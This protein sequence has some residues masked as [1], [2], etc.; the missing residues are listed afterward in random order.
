MNGCYGNPPP[1][2]LSGFWRLGKL[3][4]FKHCCHSC[5]CSR[6]PVWLPCKSPALTSAWPQPRS[7]SLW[8]EER[9]GKERHVDPTRWKPAKRNHMGSS[10]TFPIGPTAGMTY[11]RPSQVPS[12]CSRPRKDKEAEREAGHT[13]WF[14]FLLPGTAV[15]YLWAAGGRG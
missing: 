7:L 14:P 8:R 13:C 6:D 3:S 2:A 15:V 12:H 11:R 9:T 1:M 5:L 10:G 4:G